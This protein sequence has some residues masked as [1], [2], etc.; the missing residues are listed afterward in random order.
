MKGA[1][2]AA[3]SGIP[4]QLEVRVCPALGP[5]ASPASHYLATWREETVTLA[6]ASQGFEEFPSAGQR[7]SPPLQPG[8]GVSLLADAREAV[9]EDGDGWL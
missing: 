4:S 6:Q 3:E 2:P 8:T 1:L 9:W 7:G 5:T